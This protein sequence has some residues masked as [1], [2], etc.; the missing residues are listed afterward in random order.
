[1][2]F[3]KNAQHIYANQNIKILHTPI[4]LSSAMW[5]NI[6]PNYVGFTG[7]KE[8]RWINKY[9]IKTQ[10]FM[11]IGESWERYSCPTD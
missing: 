4:T 3:S 2:S 5:L 11:N 9:V 8:S 1:M 7:H 6:I 10:S